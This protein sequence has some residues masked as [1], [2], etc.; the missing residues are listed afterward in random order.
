MLHDLHLYFCLKKLGYYYEQINVVVDR[1]SRE[2]EFSS[3]FSVIIKLMR[4]QFFL[5]ESSFATI[6][7]RTWTLYVRKEKD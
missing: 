7:M 4:L 6:K 1:V 5:R 2:G 3:S